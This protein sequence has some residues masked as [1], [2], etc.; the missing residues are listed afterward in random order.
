MAKVWRTAFLSLAVIVLA[1]AMIV[2]GTYALYTDNVTVKNHLQAGTLEAKL[3]RTQLTCQKL[4]ENGYIVDG[5]KDESANPVD[6]TGET[7]QN[8]FGLEAG[9]LIAPACSYEAQ[10]RLDNVGSVALGYWLEFKV[11]EGADTALAKQ[12][13]LTVT[14]EQTETEIALDTV[15]GIITVGA[16]DNLLNRVTAGESTAF[17][18][19]VAFDDLGIP[20]NE[21]TGN[22]A[23]K[24][25][26]VSFDLIVHAVQATEA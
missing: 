26:T 6:F 19:K 13:T 23:A 17:T 21:Q 3:Y 22:N 4:D 15:G 24:A 5:S 20:E 16:N 18:V 1:A 14:V 2:A 25:Q 10:M 11:I 9:D 8:V 7:T 12:L